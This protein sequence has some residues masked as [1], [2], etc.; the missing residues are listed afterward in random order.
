MKRGSP[1]GGDELA[2][3]VVELAEAARQVDV[4]QHHAGHRGDAGGEVER[5]VDRGQAVLAGLGLGEVDTGHRGQRADR[6]DQQREH[7]ALVAERLRAEDQRGDQRHGVRLEEVGG[8]AGAVADVVAHVVRDGRRVARVVLGD[9]LLD[10]ADQVGADVGGLGEDAAADPHEHREQRRTEAEALEHVGCLVL[11]E[12]H[13]Q[14][15]AEQAQADGEHADHRA[16]AQADPHGRLAAGALGGGRDA[17]VGAHGEVHAEVADGGGE[18]GTDEEEHRAED[19][20]GGVVGRQRQQQ[21]ERHHG[22]D[23]E[24][25]ELPGQVGVGAFLDRLGDA[26]HVVGAFTGGEHLVAEHEGQSQRAERDEGDDHDQNEVAPGDFHDCG[27]D[28]GHVSPRV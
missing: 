24:R 2:R 17:Q 12:Q 1:V 4:G 16:G 9:V 21:E 23:P 13:H 7:E 27:V 15:G 25:A 8:H 20:H 10:L 28:P 18:R 3:D 22:E 5:P 6:G 26:L 11:E 14:A 19:P